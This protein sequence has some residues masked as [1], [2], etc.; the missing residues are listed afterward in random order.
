MPGSVDHSLDSRRRRGERILDVTAELILSWGC[1]RVTIDEVAKR[2][3]VGKGT[4]YLHWKARDELFHAVLMRESAAVTDEMLALMRAD[5]VE[6]L[7]H[8]LVR[9]SFTLSMRRPLLVALLTRDTDV[10]DRIVEVDVRS[11][12]TGLSETRAYLD[13]LR[14]QGLVRTELGRDAQLYVMEVVGSGAFLLEPWLPRAVA[15]DSD[16]RAATLEH[17]VRT[18]LEPAG[19]PEPATLRSAAA[20]I[21]ALFEQLRDRTAAAVHTPPV[22]ADSRTGK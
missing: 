22:A 15:L 13:L 9:N 21:I 18:A 3:G 1:R 10:L 17:L 2:A 11:G 7:P 19:S 12:D 8:R 14:E 6:V 20:N 16:A 5:P 4:V